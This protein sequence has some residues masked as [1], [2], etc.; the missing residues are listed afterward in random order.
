MMHHTFAICIVALPLFTS[1]AL[2]QNSSSFHSLLI[3][4]TFPGLQIIVIFPVL[5]PDL[6]RFILSCAVQSFTVPLSSPLHTSS[7]TFITSSALSSC[8]PSSLTSTRSIPRFLLPAFSRF[9]NIRVPSPALLSRPYILHAS[10]FP[11]PLPYPPALSPAPIAIVALTLF[12]PFPL[13]SSQPCVVK[14][15]LNFWKRSQMPVQHQCGTEAP[16]L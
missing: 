4:P 10:H 13:F 2:P 5:E 6:T 14:R 9:L 3:F 1:L 12:A 8:L 15:A 16:A 7:S 11:L